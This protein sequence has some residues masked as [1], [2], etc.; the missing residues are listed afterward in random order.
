MTAVPLGQQDSQAVGLGFESFS[1]QIDSRFIPNNFR[2]P[3]LVKH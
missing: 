3:K 1:C 2:N